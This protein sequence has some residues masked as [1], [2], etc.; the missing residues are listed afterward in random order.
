MI[1]RMVPEGVRFESVS[2]M[3]PAVRVDSFDRRVRPH[4]QSGAV[5]RY[6]QF[7]LTDRAEQD[8]GTCGAYRR[9]LLYLV[10]EAF[11]GGR[12]TPILG[13]Q[14]FFDAYGPGLPR[15]VAHVAPGPVCAATEHGAFDDDPGTRERILGF[16]QAG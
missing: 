14:K 12:S 15:T 8:D 1:D 5:Q 3:A 10:S 2:F 6:Q 13:M 11:E 7:H 16:I 4:L 9:S